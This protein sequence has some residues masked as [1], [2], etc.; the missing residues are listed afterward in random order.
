MK[1]Q[2][3]KIILTTELTD[4]QKLREDNPFSKLI[5]ECI[6]EA[7]KSGSSDIHFEPF[8][9]HYLIRFRIHG[10]LGDWRTL[11][12]K[13]AGP[14]TSKLKTILNMDLAIVGRPQDSR[15]TFS[16]LK[17]DIRASS[18]PVLG[19]KE[20]IVLRLQNQ[21]QTFD[22]EKLGLDN[23]VKEALINAI[24]K[25]DGLILIS[26]P[27][28]SGK[29]TTL[30]SLLNLMDR[31]GK[32]ISTLENPVEKRLGRINQANISDYGSFA[33]FQRALMR[34]DPDVILIGEVRDEETAKLCMKMAATG[35]LVLST[36]HANG[37]IEVIERLR[38]LG[39]DDL[40]IKSNLRLSAAQQLV[41]LICSF[42][43]GSKDG[44]EN[45]HSGISG[46]KAII[47]FIEKDLI[48]M[49]CEGKHFDLRSISDQA[50]HLASMGSIDQNEASQ[51][52]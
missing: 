10:K 42:C 49:V 37:A 16:S 52:S 1:S 36:I 39:I 18:M 23:D 30:Y 5:C 22:L 19:A 21:D 35:H 43:N 12:S 9:E 6:E 8:D 13:Y 15:A 31:H 29:T 7:K 50:Q 26:G 48:Q 38:N 14:M 33:D 47:E 40:S 45:C 25:K 46:R 11:E 28:G 41:Q 4:E 27:T 44:C 2:K 3:H 20:K 17:L 51:L 24:Y 32:N 34:Q